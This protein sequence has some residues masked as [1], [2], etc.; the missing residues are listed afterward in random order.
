[1]R[2]IVLGIGKPGAWAHVTKVEN[3]AGAYTGC[4]RRGKPVSHRRRQVPGGIR[5]APSRPAS[6]AEIR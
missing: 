2:I 4:Q 3:A 1:M 6:G 5:S